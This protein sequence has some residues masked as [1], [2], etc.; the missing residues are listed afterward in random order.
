MTGPFLRNPYLLFMTIAVVLVSGFSA[1]QSLAQIE[2]PRIAN[3]FPLVVA[4]FPGASAARVE[5]LIA[6]PLENALDEIDEI[7]NVQSTSRNGIAT[8][9]VEL[10]DDVT[11]QTNDAVFS[12]VRTTIE[13]A[14]TQL[15]AGA[16]EPSV[17]DQLVPVAFTR[18]VAL[19]WQGE[20]EPPLGVM[21][22]RA[23][24][25]ADQLRSVAGTELVR[26]YGGAQEEISVDVDG[27]ELQFLGLSVGA[28]AQRVA[29][30]DSRRPAGAL[31]SDASTLLI[32][33]DGAIDNLDR[34][35][36]IPL[37]IAPDGTALRL[38]DIARVE[39]AIEEPVKAIGLVDGQRAVLV[40]A[41]MGVDVRVGPWAEEVDSRIDQFTA[42]DGGAIAIE[43][44]FDQSEYTR[45]R[46]GE[47][48]TSLGLGALVVMAVVLLTM[49]WRLALLVGA[50][51]PLTAAAT[52][53]G[54]LLLGGQIHQMSI[55]GMIIAMGLLIDN[56][57]VVVDEIRKRRAAGLPASEAVEQTSAH[58][59]G[60]LFA[61]T[62]TTVL[63]FAPIVLLPGPA[64]DFVG[65]IG[66]SVILAITSSYFLSLTVIAA[67]AG[68][69]GGEVQTSDATGRNVIA[70][71]LDGRVLSSRFRAAMETGLK[72]PLLAMAV[73]ASIPILGFGIGSQLGRSFFPPTD[74]D[75]FD[76]QVWLPADASIQRT[77]D[78]VQR[79]ED[80]IRSYP[81][82][83]R[84][85]WLAGG[86][87]PSVYYNLVMNTIDTPSYARGVIVVDSAESTE[88]LVPLLQR[89]IDRGF[90][91][92]QA[93]VRS[94]GQGPPIEADV[95]YRIF[96]PSI[97][98]L[99]ELGEELRLALQSHPQ[100]LHTQVSMPRGEPK[101]WLEAD[102][103]ETERAGLT[104]TDV[105]LQL[106][107][108]LEG[109]SGGVLL[110]D[111]EQMPVRFRID[112]A[113][114]DLTELESLRLSTSQGSTPLE[115]L[116]E[117]A[118]RPELGGISRYGGERCNTVF[119]YTAEGALAIDVSAQVL[120]GLDQVGFDLP[121]GYRLE[122]GGSSEE[123]QEAVGNLLA[124]VPVLMTIMIAAVVLVFRSL[125][126]A[127][128]LLLVAFMSVGLALLSTSF[129][130]FPISFNTIL[131]TLG[132]IGVAL[133]DSIVVLA[134]I[135]ENPRARRGDHRAILDEVLGCTRHIVSTTLTTMGGFLPLLLFVGGEFWPS[136][137]IVLVGGVG[138]ATILALIFVPAAYVLLHRGRGGVE[139]TAPDPVLTRQERLEAAEASA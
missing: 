135:R 79:I 45:A 76:I 61:S 30:A 46:L 72:R 69:Y 66:I 14:A 9:S 124:Y 97:E 82:V 70:H 19:L 16:L 35:R 74:R 128:I 29:A 131:G 85:H 37:Q 138:G 6:E 88:R 127:G 20:G 53:F 47:L 92:A 109:V 1:L 4:P 54:V 13:E 123:D 22:R 31:R 28:L 24:D 90:P 52:L 91:E 26:V 77:V 62:L 102:E 100:I 58:L 5:A 118:L 3:R 41:R 32:E 96:G 63:A 34:V 129:M 110:E 56:A 83:E 137:A 67:L 126:I 57:I 125:R 60:P 121:D 73:A 84:V 7:K 134:A 94:F 43:T 10:A 120:A 39:R 107:A 132:L 59:R 95:Q 116:G 68:R 75:M 87:F 48:M 44:I 139:D 21:T 111:L 89:E 114:S 80:R 93:V 101:L 71:G 65:Y 49:G 8:L 104:L 103:I 86:S 25:L 119:G 27:D 42:H 130:G 81:E 33:V 51:L 38:G 78:A 115:A 117:L 99:Q 106:D 23:E 40:G 12:R 122:V 64:G 15:P 108:G 17:D 18:I 136:L 2:D 113:R 105:A 98:R 133:N 50:A 36:A 11:E 112:Q 55:F